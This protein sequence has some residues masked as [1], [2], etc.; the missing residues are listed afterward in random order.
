[1]E[2]NRLKGS[3]YAPRTPAETVAVSRAEKLKKEKEKATR[4]LG[5]LYWKAESLSAS[6]TRA[7]EILDTGIDSNAYLDRGPE[8]RYPFVLVLRMQGTNTK[9]KQAESMFKVDFFEFYTLLE[10]YIELCLSIVGVIVSGSVNAAGPRTNFNHLRYITNPDLRRTHPEASHAFHAN[11]LDALEAE[12][13]PLHTSLGNDDVQSQLRLA[14]DYRNRWKDADENIVTNK[15]DSREE[16]VKRAIKLA[17][18]DLNRML[19]MLLA[20]C[21]HA[22]GVVDGSTQV[23]ANSTNSRD[24]ENG[25]YETMD[26][27]V[28][29]APLEYMYDAMD[30]D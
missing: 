3:K 5:R 4:L 13:C 12:T 26:M 18:L 28:Y 6:Y 21:Q 9:K 15:W 22:H 1:M 29:D 24:F 7:I 27:D 16:E 20:G 17:D 19:T 11:L 2:T 30:L 10:R 23:P 8:T 14:K 25:N